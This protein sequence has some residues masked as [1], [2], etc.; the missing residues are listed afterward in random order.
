MVN[1]WDKHF[2]GEFEGKYKSSET[3]WKILC[4]K[5]AVIKEFDSNLNVKVV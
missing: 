1:V 5:M 3:C 2:L 4:N